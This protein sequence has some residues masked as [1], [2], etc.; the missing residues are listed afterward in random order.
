MC[1]D[2]P[3]GDEGRRMLQFFLY[4]IIIGLVINLLADMV[5]KYLPG[6]RRMDIIVTAIL[7]SICIVLLIYHKAETQKKTLVRSLINTTHPAPRPI[8]PKKAYP[9]GSLRAVTC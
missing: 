5:W 8:L 1:K 2:I 3:I 6:T 4:T 9:Q 7:V